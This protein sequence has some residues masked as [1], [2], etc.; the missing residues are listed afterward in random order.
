MCLDT[1]R[2]ILY[3]CDREGMAVQRCAYDGTS[4]ETIVQVAAPSHEKMLDQ[5]KHCVGIAID[6]ERGLCYWTQKGSAGAA[7]GTLMCCNLD[8]PPAKE[9]VVTMLREGLETPIHICLRQSTKELL[10]VMRNPGEVVSF[11]LAED[12]LRVLSESV[13]VSGLLH[14][15]CIEDDSERLLFTELGHGGRVWASNKDGSNRRVLSKGQEFSAYSGV[16]AIELKAAYDAVAVVPNEPKFEG[17]ETFEGRL[18]HSGRWPQAR[19]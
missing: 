12:R 7:N 8:S 2:Q 4:L 5:S 11:T 15:C 6:T 19:L 14:A 17:I 13:I 3:F 9:G 10:C 1:E 16:C 18:L